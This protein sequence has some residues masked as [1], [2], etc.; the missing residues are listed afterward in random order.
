M[1]SFSTRPNWKASFVRS[2]RSHQDKQAA[3]TA[4]KSLK[5][6]GVR[7]RIRETIDIFKLDRQLTVI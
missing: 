2:R 1:R 4:G 6:S 7:G 5:I 3:G